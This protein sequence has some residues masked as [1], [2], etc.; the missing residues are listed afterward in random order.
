MTFLVRAFALI[1]ASALLGPFIT[2]HPGD[3]PTI[4]EAALGQA[5]AG[6][7]GGATAAIAA[8][9]GDRNLLNNGDFRTGSG[10]SPDEWRTGAWKESPDATTYQWLHS[11]SEEPELTITNTERNDAR[12][13]QSLTL[14]P[15]WYYVSA[16]VRAGNVGSDAAGANVSLDEDGINSPDL[17]GTTAWQRL[18]FYLKVGPHGADVDVALRLGGFSSLNRGQAFFR[19]AQV[20]KIAA[21]PVGAGPAFDLTAVRNSE[22]SPPIGTPWTLPAVFV[23][24]AIFLVIG[25]FAYGATEPAAAALPPRA[26]RRR[27]RG[28]A[29]RRRRS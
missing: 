7:A 27:E 3:A 20:K 15:G 23:L 9:A 10:E 21:L 17:H 26:A 28:G 11:Q 24:L 14:G 6:T 1:A 4:V 19:E 5:S 12:W 13:L 2:T 22:A 25:W 18:G 29:R 8:D 16:E